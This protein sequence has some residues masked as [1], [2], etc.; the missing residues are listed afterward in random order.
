MLKIVRAGLFIA[1]V[2]VFAHSAI[3]EEA[4]VRQTNAPSV[5]DAVAGAPLRSLVATPVDLGAAKAAV[6]ST[7]FQPSNVAQVYQVGAYNNATVSQTGAGN[8]ATLVQQGQGNT[9]LISQT[10]RGR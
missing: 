5:G 3:A 2:Q 8:V 9:A 7:G 6:T 1:T 4:Y 10:S